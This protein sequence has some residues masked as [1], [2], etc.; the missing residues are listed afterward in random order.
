LRA[1]KAL[2]ADP[3][4]PGMQNL[5]FATNVVVMLET[6]VFFAGIIH[7]LGIMS[8]TSKIKESN[9]KRIERLEADIATIHRP[10]RIVRKH[11]SSI[12]DYIE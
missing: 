4:G 11:G 7:L 12:L 10:A 3:N 8:E 1:A 6:V 9:A 5:F 2:G